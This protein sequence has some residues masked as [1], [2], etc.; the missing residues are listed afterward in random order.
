MTVPFSNFF[1]FHPKNAM[2]IITVISQYFSPYLFMMYREWHFKYLRL[3]IGRKNQA[4]IETN[5]WLKRR[6]EE[7][8]H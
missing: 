7:Q 6:R 5:F 2:Y 1:Y 3:K 4:F 8:R